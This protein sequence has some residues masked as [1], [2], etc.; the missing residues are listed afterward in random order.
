VI[1]LVKT[2][3]QDLI[4]RKHHT[5]PNSGTFYKI[6]GSSSSQVKWALVILATHEA[7]IKRSKASSTKEFIRPY[8][9]KQTKK[10]SKRAGGVAQGV[11]PEFKP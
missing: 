9:K 11:G 7:E 10:K 5:D 8:C 1:F 4:M 6:P 3:K 2:N